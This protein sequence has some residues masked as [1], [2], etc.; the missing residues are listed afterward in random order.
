MKKIFTLIIA[1]IMGAG[2]LF[3]EGGNCGKDGSTVKWNLT[4]GVLIISGEGAM[5][6]FE[7]SETSPDK[8]PWWV[9]RYTIE[10]IQIKSGVTYI[11]KYAFYDC[12][13]VYSV[14][15]GTGVKTIAEG[16]FDNC[17]VELKKITI[18]S[19]VE[20]IRNFAFNYC[21][22]LSSV[23]LSEGVKTIGT[24]AFGSCDK[25]TS[26][27]IPSTMER[28]SKSA[29]DSSIKTV[30]FN[31]RALE[32]STSSSNFSEPLFSGATSITFGDKVERI[33]DYICVNGT[34]LKSVS[35]GKKVNTIGGHA[36]E[37]CTNLESPIVLPES[38]DT[39]DFYAF[40][41]CTK[42]PSVTFNENLKYIRNYAFSQC[43]GLKS[44]VLNGTISVLDKT[45]ESCTALKSLT[46]GKDVKA[47]ASDAF[48]NS[49]L[50]SVV[51]D[52]QNYTYGAFP[53]SYAKTK[54][55][56]FGFGEN[57]EHIPAGLCAGMEY[58]TSM[59]IPANVKTIGKDVFEGC[60]GLKS[61]VWNAKNADD[62]TDV[63]KAPF[64]AIRQQIT[65]FVIG[66]KV[67]FIPSYLCYEMSNLPMITLPASVISIGNHAFDGCTI[68]AGQDLVIPNDVMTLGEYAFA[69][70]NLA[71]VTIGSKVNSIGK[72]AFMG[73]DNMTSVYNEAVSPQGITANV[74][75]DLNKSACDLYV[76]ENSIPA[77]QGAEVWKNFRSFNPLCRLGSG[78]DSGIAWNLSCSGKL[79]ITGT[80][81]IP[82]YYTYESTTLCTAPWYGNSKPNHTV[83][84]A[85]ISDGITRVGN[86]AFWQCQD[87]TDVYIPN[88]V[89]SIGEY[90][91]Y[92]NKALQEVTLSD[93]IESIGQQA[94]TQCTSLT[95]LRL[96]IHLKSIE[97]T[98]FA[99]CSGL[100]SVVIPDEVE[101][102]R[103]EAFSYCTKLTELTIPASVTTIDERAFEGCSKLTAIWN[104]ATTPQNIKSNVFGGG[105][106]KSKCKLY[107]PKEAVAAYMNAPVWKEFDI[108]AA[109]GI[110]A[111]GTC[112]AQGDNLTW[113]LT[114]DGLLTIVGTGEMEAFS[115]AP[116][117][118]WRNSILSVVIENG[119]TTISPVAFMSCNF[120]SHVEIPSTVTTIG[121]GAF[122][123]CY[124]LS[125]ITI[126]NSVKSLGNYT[127]LQCSSLS[128]ITIPEGV[129]TI[130]G[131]TFSECVSLTDV[132]LPSTIK[133]LDASAFSKCASLTTISLPASIT[134]I[135]VS[136][137]A[138]CYALESVTNEAVTPQTINPNVFDGLTLSDIRLY[139]YESVLEDYK[140]AAVWKEFK[141]ILPIDPSEK[142]VYTITFINW[143][144]SELLKLTDVEEGTKPVYTGPTPTRPEDEDY[145]YTFIGWLP[146]IVAATSDATY[147][148]TFEATAKEEPS[149]TYYTVRFL[150]WDDSLLKK[151]SVEK[152]KDA[153][154]PDDPVREGYEF[155]GWS[156]DYTNIQSDMNIYAQYVKSDQALDE[157]S[158]YSVPN[159]I[160][161]N[162]QLFILRDGKVYTVTGQE[163]R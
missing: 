71:S 40:S 114:T 59:T 70:C 143:D 51:W 95:T 112:G 149:V 55:T 131:L 7:Y 163:V 31:A 77:Y 39:I 26:I 54:I 138:E 68:W 10:S 91:F 47:V 46:L 15:I 154:P 157:I 37:N 151:Q 33:P 153:T 73:S 88:S 103:D 72:Y 28:M 155:T 119:A 129:T 30:V 125:E 92:Y 61:V 135:G 115:Q 56:S 122:T 130:G 148:A 32:Y 53:F 44:A 83:K 60:T 22:N 141:P 75:G 120:L 100:T 108:Q 2:T 12:K 98:A 38:L 89:T 126:P 76:P 50:E 159:K 48:K 5:A 152:G 78:T 97:S 102:I 74:F 90:A 109:E 158:T 57:V 142:K 156:A 106:D 80:G 82:D 139:V 27:T 25:L 34:S 23:H 145:T 117:Y 49:P 69:N 150:D 85:E 13:N 52:I 11:G 127:F 110:L 104:N 118:T 124:A 35:F 66:D 20:N 133:S 101:A 24:G 21:K 121:D 136:A 19:N 134:T 105:L 113:T 86:Y 43:T 93:N 128:S 140:A 3:A 111:S 162:G 144:G 132:K 96:P 1:L 16:A 36:F 14:S 160:L 94:F 62:I 84:S 81:A 63:A 99:L 116:W 64:S 29:F 8:S 42:I 41:G 87:M 123:S 67:T 79:S 146:S 17:Y 9:D 65:S 4:D 45:F 18:P 161:R 107:V 137:F 58:I 147:T 6:D